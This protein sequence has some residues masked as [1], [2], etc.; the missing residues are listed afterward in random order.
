MSFQQSDNCFS[1][2][3]GSASPSL[4]ILDCCKVSLVHH[5]QQTL[6]F[7]LHVDHRG[8]L[9]MFITLHVLGK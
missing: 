6:S 2:S 3:E 9:N 7:L 5:D 4:V 1:Y 8:P